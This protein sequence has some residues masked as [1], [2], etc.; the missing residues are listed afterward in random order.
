MAAILE[1][2]ITPEHF[3]QIS[4]FTV[5][6]GII[7]MCINVS[8]PLLDYK[9]FEG[10]NGGWFI[11]ISLVSYWLSYMLQTFNACFSNRI[12]MAISVGSTCQIEKITVQ[13]IIIEYLL[14]SIDGFIVGIEHFLYLNGFTVYREMKV[15]KHLL[16]SVL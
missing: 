9:F 4:I 2:A 16:G 1:I 8:C 3:T 10:G 12:Y 15:I 13:L 14:N 5:F 6:L 11:F 7:C